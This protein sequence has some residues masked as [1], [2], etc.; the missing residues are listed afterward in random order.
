MSLQ[1]RV[2]TEIEE[3]HRVFEDW[4]AGSAE[5]SLA[6]VEDALAPD[7]EI[8]APD[9]R[10]LARGP[11]LEGLGAARG[12]RGDGLRIG[13]RAVRARELGAGLVL[14]YYEEWQESPAE[15]PRGRLSSA[16]LRERPGGGFDWLSVHET[17]LPR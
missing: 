3:L 7:F 17:W 1:A 15:A 8:V 2:R 16:L 11:L 12:G 9:G 14:A 5:A 6:R 4:L 13:I 10:Q